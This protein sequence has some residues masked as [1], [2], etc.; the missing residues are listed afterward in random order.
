MTAEQLFKST[1]RYL[2]ENTP[3][4]LTSFA[5]VGVVSTAIFAVKGTPE[6]MDR[7][8]VKKQ[9]VRAGYIQTDRELTKMEV[10][11]VAWRPYLPAMLMGTS[12]IAAIIASRS[13][14]N[15]R[16]AVLAAA[17]SLSE[18]AYHEYRERTREEVGERKEEQ[19]RSDVA[20]RRYEQEQTE[21]GGNREV[22]IIGNGDILCFETSSGRAFMSDKESIRR[23]END[24]NAEILHH[25]HATLS[26]FY[27]KIGLPV[28]T[29][30]ED[31][32]WNTN[33][34]L[35]IDYSGFVT[36]DDRPALA[37]DY[38]NSPIREPWK[39][40]WTNV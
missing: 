31:L 39:D 29:M 16:N 17:Y 40:P 20:S 32:G 33:T 27:R 28:T 23:A 22:I 38:H 4:I 25:G 11:K 13:I 18:R 9:Q 6:A 36:A 21:P 15:K 3:T 30:S 35:S 7:I 8:A 2:N 24:I 1:V 26:D 19:I 34:T 12:T 37:I 14:D 5:A 10:V